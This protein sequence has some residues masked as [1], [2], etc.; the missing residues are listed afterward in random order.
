M[1]QRPNDPPS[2]P[3]DQD[4]GEHL[5]LIELETLLNQPPSQ[6]KRLVQI[7]LML[8]AFLVV[9]V[10]FWDTIVP[11]QPSVPPL[12]VQAPPPPPTVS[13]MS[14]VNYGA[15]TINGQPQ[16]G[17]LPLTIKLSSQPPYTI[18]LNAPPFQ[19][20]TCHFPPPISIVPYAFHPCDAGRTTALNQEASNTLEILFTL[21]DLPAAQRQ[22][23][24]ALISRELTAQQ[25]INV[26]AQSFIVTGLNRDGTLK[27]RRL[28]G[29]LHASALLVP[30]APNAQRGVFC[31]SFTCAVLGGFPHDYSASGQFW[32]V[33]TPFALRWRFTTASGQVVSDILFPASPTLLSL[34]LTYD[35]VAGWQL[36][37]LPSQY[38]SLSYQLTQL[39]CI[40][41]VQ[42]LSV[43]QK[44]SLRG[45]GW[46]ITILH[47]QGVA[48]CEL[49]LQQNNVDQG[50]FVWR[51][52]VL[53]AADARAHKTLP[54]LPIAPSGELAAVGG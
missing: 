8:A 19:P 25:T 21:A 48:G 14:N 4:A 42:M 24:T 1:S 40:T 46:N 44:R 20:R 10:T 45:A 32:Q 31:F 2:P 47:D 7:S 13:I 12:P 43:E 11:S 39:V 37:P 18:T 16:R 15:L 51:F 29:P 52:G 17:V 5:P 27:T 49:E 38:V 35:A 9:V 50:R 53:L 54:T 33:R 26:P 22:Q 3:E 28:T 23:I 6:R 34:F 30:S 41:G 36:G